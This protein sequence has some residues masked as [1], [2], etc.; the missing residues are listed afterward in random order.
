VIDQTFDIEAAAAAAGLAVK[1][2]HTI[3]TSQNS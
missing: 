3:C 1:I 2:W